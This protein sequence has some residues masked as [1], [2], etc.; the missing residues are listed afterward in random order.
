MQEIKCV[1]DHSSPTTAGKAMSI[2]DWTDFRPKKFGR[3]KED[4]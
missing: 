1:T 3:S 4:H 2:S